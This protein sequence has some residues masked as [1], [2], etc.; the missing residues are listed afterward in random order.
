[1][2]RGAGKLR[3]L[4]LALLSGLLGAG[5]A[6]RGD[7]LSYL[8]FEPAFMDAAIRLGRHDGEALL[9]RPPLWKDAEFPPR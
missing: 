8:F 3:H 5:P 2:L 4:D 1:V 7:L 6:S 9:D